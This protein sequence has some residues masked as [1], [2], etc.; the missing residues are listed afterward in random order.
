MSTS[1]QVSGPGRVELVEDGPSAP[2]GAH[3]VAGRTLAS[4]V[5]PGTELASAFA[6]ADPSG[7][8]FPRRIG[9]AA[10]FEIDELGADVRELSVGDRVF[11]A[12]PHAARQRADAAAVVPLPVGLD[13]SDAVFARMIAVPMAALVTTRARPGDRVGI[14]GLGLVGNLAAKAFHASGYRVTAWDPVAERRSHLP[15]GVAVRARADG[16]EFELVV[17]ASG[18]DGAALA[19]ARV[20][21][22]GGELVLTGTPWARRS[23]A[24]AHELL[25]LVFHR[26][27][28][29]RSGWEWQLPMQPS[30]FRTGSVHG[31]FRRAIDWLADGTVRVDG[32]A[33]V[34]P[35]SGAQPAFEALAGRTASELTVV[36]DWS[37]A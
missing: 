19:A 36:F 2:L 16:D 27:L 7:V 24:S 32:L 23:D 9:Y 25:H 3:E 34:V 12:G 22:R 11:H 15:D 33:R 5:S 37:G 30:D 31:N 6:P 35:P 4:L 21:A 14:S 18:H 26:Y 8:E 1:L 17:E 13:P 28:H 20:V 29:V 10:V